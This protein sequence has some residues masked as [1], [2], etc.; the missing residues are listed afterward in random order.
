MGFLSLQNRIAR[1]LGGPPTGAPA[2]PPTQRSPERTTGLLNPTHIAILLI[3]VLIV[4]GPK[5]LPRPGRSLGRG[6]R[7]FRD[8]IAG[9]GD[10]PNLA[11]AKTTDSRKTPG[12]PPASAAGWFARC[13]RNGMKPTLSRRAA[14]PVARYSHGR[15]PAAGGVTAA[16]RC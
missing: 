16:A 6:M 3:V 9:R 15:R 7:E 12:H 2:T 5:R 13:S 11:L 4:L 8:G 10:P 14:G 1:W